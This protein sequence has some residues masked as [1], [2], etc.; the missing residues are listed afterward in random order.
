LTSKGFNID[1]NKNFLSR[2][3]CLSYA[4]NIVKRYGRWCTYRMLYKN[5]DKLRIAQ[6]IWFHAIV[7]YVGTPIKKILK[8]LKITSKWLDDIIERAE[9]IEINNNDNRSWAF[10][11]AW[12]AAYYI[13]T[14]LRSVIGLYGIYSYIHI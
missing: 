8:K 7:Y 12:W 1:E 10:V 2:K 3:F 11:I 5:M 9:H 6:E 14:C 13:K 4:G